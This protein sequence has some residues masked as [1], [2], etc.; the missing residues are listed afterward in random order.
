MGDFTLKLLKN[1]VKT[2]LQ[3]ENKYIITDAGF[4]NIWN[5]FEVFKILFTEY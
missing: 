5:T 1:T 2:I 3:R 4:K